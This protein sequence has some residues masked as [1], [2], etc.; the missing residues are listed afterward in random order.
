MGLSHTLTHREGDFG[1]NA[2]RVLDPEGSALQLADQTVTASQANNHG[3]CDRVTDQMEDFPADT[4]AD[5]DDGIPK[6]LD[7]RTKAP[8]PDDWTFHL[9]DE[10]G[11]PRRQQ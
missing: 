8:D 11:A 3:D 1:E 9:D 10:R 4:S 2:P 6:F 7:R 5:L